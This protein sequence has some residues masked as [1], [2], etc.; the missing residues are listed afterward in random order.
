MITIIMLCIVTSIF[1]MV[2]IVDIIILFIT[3]IIALI[4]AQFFIFFPLILVAAMALLR[5]TG[6]RFINDFPPAGRP[7]QNLMLQQQEHQQ[8]QQG[9]TSLFC[10]YN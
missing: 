6:L 1:N 9:Y 5:G 7:E 3:I 4:N 10:Y 8:Q 2:I